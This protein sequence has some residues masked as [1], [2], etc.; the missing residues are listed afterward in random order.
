MQ[1]SKGRTRRE[2]TGYEAPS[3]G[4]DDC[5]MRFMQPAIIIPNHCSIEAFHSGINRLDKYVAGIRHYNVLY[6][7]NQSLMSYPTDS[8]LSEH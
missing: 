5:W 1:A 3:E 2:V 4:E 7:K 8:F 6:E